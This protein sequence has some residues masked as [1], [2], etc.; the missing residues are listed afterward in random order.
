MWSMVGGRNG[1][2][3]RLYFASK[4]KLLALFLNEG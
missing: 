3:I 1:C 4:Y 2:P